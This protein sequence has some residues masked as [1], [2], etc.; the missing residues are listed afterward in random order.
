MNKFVKSYWTLK[1]MSMMKFKKTQSKTQ[2]IILF[3]RNILND[4][5]F[6]YY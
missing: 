1:E 6:I 2:V 5:Q 4:L 3:M